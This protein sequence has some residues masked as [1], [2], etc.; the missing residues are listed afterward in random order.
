MTGR[1]QTTFL[2]TLL[3]WLLD[4]TLCFFLYVQ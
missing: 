4:R 2:S 3:L 1:A